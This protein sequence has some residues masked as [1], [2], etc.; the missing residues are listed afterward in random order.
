MSFNPDT[1]KQAIEV[2][3][4]CKD[5]KPD[6]P[7]LTFNGV[8]IARKPFTK[9][10]GVYLDS[11]L[12]LSK[13]I[14]KKVAIATKGLRLLR[15]L[16]KFVDRNVL[17]MSYEMYIRLHLD[18]GDVLYH[19]LRTDLMDLLERIQ[20]KAALIVS[21]CWQGTSRKKMCEELGWESLSDRRWLR[22]LT[23]FYKIAKGLP[24]YLSTHIPK[25]NEINMV[26]RN[27]C[28]SIPFTRTKRHEISFF[29][30]TIKRWKNLDENAKS[31]P[32]TESF[33]KY[34]NNCI[35]P[36]G[37]PVFVI[38]DRYG[39]NLLIQ[40]RVGFTDLREDRFH[41][42]FNYRNPVCRCG[43]DDETPSHFF[44]RCPM[45]ALERTTLLMSDVI[46]F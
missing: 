1:T 19:N 20:Y 6:H 18:Y 15:F 27:R 26:L 43:L 45:F 30:Y 33:K 10:L 41:H 32:Y 14:R 44:P 25:R 17:S 39:I 37:N 46:L 24:P 42:N 21:G 34:I 7:E 13:H 29:P 11:R 12:N 35:R 38:G 36:P 40:I 2:V 22:R 5:N 9:H 8:P 16:T 4:S 28:E 23:I 3:F 31:K